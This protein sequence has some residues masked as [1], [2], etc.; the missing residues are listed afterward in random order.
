MEV[1]EIQCD[2]VLKIKYNEAVIP[3][4]YYQLPSHYSEMR[5]FA[6]RTLAILGS[7]YLCEQLFLLMKANMSALKSRLTAEN[8]SSI[9]K[10]ASSQ[11]Q[12]PHIEKLVSR[13][14]CLMS[15]KK[16]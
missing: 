2:S 9:L 16:P 5:Q 6:A 15:I 10:I 3:Q 12:K 4:F 8:L 7:A 11:N 1:T 13:K 14:R